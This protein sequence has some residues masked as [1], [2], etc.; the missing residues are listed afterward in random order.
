MRWR[1]FLLYHTLALLL[2]LSWLLPPA[3][4]LW[5][6]FDVAVFQ[7]LNSSVAHKPL[8]QIF[9]ALANVKAS[10]LF[11]ALFMASFSLIYVCE[12]GK[13]E[14]KQRLAQFFYICIWWEIG[15]LILKEV[16]FRILVAVNF[17]RDSP[18]LLFD[19]T[20]KL[21]E[22]A[23]WLKIKDFS[24]WSFPGD[25]AFIIFQWA[26][27]IAFFCGWRYGLVAYISSIFFIAPRLIAGAHWVSDAIAGSL[28]LTLIF[29]AWA[30]ATPLYAW[31]MRYLKRCTTFILG[32]SYATI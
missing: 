14:A 26:A 27:F 31:S 7:F 23:P 2:F 6:Q 15:I 19:T 17:L 24:H 18:S 32:R 10:D 20:I 1:P 3:S 5:Q 9:W 22:A 4:Q 12:N 25:H 30:T 11:G 28:P 16:I 21:S 8:H 13:E 29:L